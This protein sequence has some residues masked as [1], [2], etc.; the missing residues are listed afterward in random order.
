M[1]L[2]I[3]KA[4]MRYKVTQFMKTVGFQIM[5]CYSIQIIFIRY[6]YETD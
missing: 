3:I 4:I 5:N 1:G 2:I 6:D